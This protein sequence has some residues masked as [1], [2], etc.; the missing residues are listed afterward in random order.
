[1]ILHNSIL[2]LLIFATVVSS[3]PYS[4]PLPK[5]DQKIHYDDSTE[6]QSIDTKTPYKNTKDIDD[7]LSSKTYSLFFNNNT[8][9]WSDNC[10]ASNAPV[11]WPVAVA[12]KVVANTKDS[13]KINNVMSAFKSY[14]NSNG[15]YSA[16]MAGDDQ[17][18]TDD[19]G[20]ISWVFSSAYETTDK[21]DYLSENKDLNKYLSEQEDDARGGGVKWLVTS[22]YIALISNLEVAVAAL[23]LNEVSGDDDYVSFAKDLIVWTLENLVDN[24]TSNGKFIYDGMYEDGGINKGKLTYTVGTL[25]SACA[26]LIK[27]GDND[28]DWRNIA[29]TFGVRLISGG[30]LDNQFFTDGH[31]NDIVDRSHLVFVGFA[32]L[33]EMTTPQS[34]YE[35]D[36]Y[37][38]FKEFLQ[39]EARYFYDQNSDTINSKSC[40]SNDYN[41]LLKYSSLAQVF[42]E[43]ARVV[44]WI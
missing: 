33:L 36:A 39:R 30:K 19:N 28:Q 44:D 32:D 22:T 34:D 23:R 20:Q 11:V 26:H 38:A 24:L 4:I 13:D 14:R 12:G 17:I 10:N 43:T 35:E 27:M 31:M 6:I 16:S 5:R 41:D 18:Y 2:I 3:L 37:D 21:E 9:I 29:V 1:M 7:L 25:I 15:G 42:Y 40:P 8:G